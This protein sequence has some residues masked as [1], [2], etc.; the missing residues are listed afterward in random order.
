ME[1]R[2]LDDADRPW[3]HDACEREWG[4]PVVSPSG[5]WDPSTLDGFLAVDDGGEPLGAVAYRV[6]T[7]QCEIVALFSVEER[8]G[9]GTAL[10][11][12]VARAATGCWRLW[13]ITTNDNLHALGF[14]QRRGWDLV[15]LHRDWIDHV[16]RL[17]PDVGSRQSGGI[18][19]RHAIEL[20]LRL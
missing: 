7:G 6:V 17:K 13:L 10:L 1:V 12:A 3:V 2:P 8:R 14:Y 20:E 4:L 11:D 16:R 5:A 18:P 15:A 19:F 9:I